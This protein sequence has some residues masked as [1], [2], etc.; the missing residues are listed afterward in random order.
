VIRYREDAMKIGVMIEGQEGLTWERWFRIAERVEALGLD[1]LWRSD[2]FMSVMRRRRPALECWV[3]LTALAQRSARIQFG[4]LVSPM[5]FRH[6]ALLA[7]MAAAVQELCGGRLVLG[8][9]AGW[10]QAEHDAFGISL[11]PAPERFDRMEEGIEVITRLF[12][13]GPADFDGRYYPLRQAV[14]SPLPDSPP[15]LLIG[16]DGKVRILGMVARYAGEWNSMVRSPAAYDEARAALDEHCR[17]LGRD[18]ASIRRSWMNGVIIGRDPAHLEE[19][20]RWHRA[21]LPSLEGLSTAEVRRRQ[22]ERSWL[23]GTPEEVA[24]QLRPWS[25]AGVQRVMLQWFDLDNLEDLSL[26]ARVQAA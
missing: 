18:P 2:H 6:P 20:L 24:E 26:L 25:R 15:P 13:G 1:S 3:S 12:R 8:L 10:N 16:G 17:R 21:F 9:G 5:T 7:R 22:Q 14:L 23:V 19:R 11:P 4:P